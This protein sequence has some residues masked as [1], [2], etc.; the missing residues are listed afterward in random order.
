MKS[1]VTGLFDMLP[2]NSNYLYRVCKKYVDRYN[3]ENNNDMY[4][5]GEFRFLKD[6]LKR[7]SVVFDAGANKGNWSKMVLRIN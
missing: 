5:N 1:I 7:C 4:T 2:E 3:N 6:K